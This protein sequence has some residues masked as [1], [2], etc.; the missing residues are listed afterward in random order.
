[1]PL[2]NLFT[3]PILG[4]LL[5]GVAA[6]AQ[7][8]TPARPHLDAAIRHYHELEYER[9]LQ[10]L[11]EAQGRAETQEER[12]TTLLYQGIILFELNRAQ[13]ARTAFRAALELQHSATLPVKVSPKIALDF[14]A[15]REQLQRQ[16]A[17]QQASDTPTVEAP[18]PPAL[19]SAETAGPE[20]PIGS[21]SPPEAAVEESR[22]WFK[23]WYVWTAVGAV[24]TA[25]AVGTVLATATRDAPPPL[26]EGDVC[27]G[28]CD[29]VIGGGLIR[30]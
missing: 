20:L 27:S 5:L 9:A 13:E 28:S 22:P 16:A 14:Q 18:S 19:L 10:E 15:Q 26:S 12:V 30:F 21:A 7:E 25:A 2:K 17:R 3:L 29:P 1:M 24:V 6:Q 8:R 23:R 11:R 4:L